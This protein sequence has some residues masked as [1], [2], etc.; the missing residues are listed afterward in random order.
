MR[1]KKKVARRTARGG[2]PIRAPHKP[3][4]VIKVKREP[5]WRPKMEE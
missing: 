1:K 5:K 2:A 4:R 3:T